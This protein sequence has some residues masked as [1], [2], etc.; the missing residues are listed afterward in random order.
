MSEGATVVAVSAVL[1]VEVPVKGR[2]PSATPP[3][4]S[5]RGVL[6][7]G[8]A[9]VSSVVPAAAFAACRSTSLLPS[10]C[11]SMFTLS[12]RLSGLNRA[13]MCSQLQEPA[14]KGKQGK[15]SALAGRDCYAP[16]KGLL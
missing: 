5:A 15:G 6:A 11:S 4:A 12:V 7:T 8:A 1:L 10:G 9:A 3:G 14:A 13:V 2:C 16:N